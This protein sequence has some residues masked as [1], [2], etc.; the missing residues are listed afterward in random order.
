MTTKQHC[1]RR[2]RSTGSTLM[3]IIVSLAVVLAL[4]GTVAVYMFNAG[5]N[6]GDGEMIEPVKLTSFVHDVVEAGEVESSENEEIRCH[7]KSK[8]TSGTAILWVI[9]EGTYVDQDEVLVKL[10]SSAL[11][12]E[13]LSEKI[14]YNNKKAAMIQA[15]SLWEAAIKAKQEYE[16]GTFIQE[17]QAAEAEVFVAEENLRR[18]QQVALYS[19]R[20]AV[21]GYVTALQL[22]SD[23]FAVEKARKDVE[24]ANTR[25][26][27][28][29][30]FTKGKMVRQ[31]ESDIASAK[32]AY[33]AEKSSFELEETR[34]KEIKDQIAACTL[35]APQAGQV[36]YVNKRDR[37]GNNEFVV[38][39]G[40]L[41]REQQAIIRLPNSNRMQVK[42]KVSEAKISLI[43]RGMP[44]TVTIDAFDSLKLK[45]VVT[46][47]NQYPE[48]S[49]F[50]NANVKEYQTI[51]E[52]EDPPK[53]LKPG[54]TAKVR[55]HTQY[56]KEALQVPI[57]AI[58][59][60]R[61]RYYCIVRGGNAW[62]AKPVVLGPSN[63]KTVVIKE[64]ILEGE[65]VA[66]DP[67]RQLDEVV[68][69][70]VPEPG[71]DEIAQAQREVIAINNPAS[72]PAVS[73]EPSGTGRGQ[74]PPGG[75]AGL[76]NSGGSG[77]FPQDPAE[78]AARMFTRD[79]NGDGKLSPDE[80]PDRIRDQF[81]V[82]DSNHDGAIDRAEMTAAMSQ[83]SRG[84][85][86]PSATGAAE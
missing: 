83:F 49:S 76:G 44:V 45:G 30:K 50:F 71:A 56:I 39:A 64:G 5:Q 55:I 10:D 42:T 69:P 3:F 11:E 26:H 73:S 1:L 36:V 34:L 48:P 79:A 25:L 63:E 2:T 40:A 67:A 74:S 35:R 22:E 8:N 9:A 27:V 12:Q 82:I 68:L 43:R 65:L 13:L 23:R 60:H 29:V 19:E 24:A 46:K 16:D 47:V 17:R 78:M 51:V 4:V 77:G 84:S 75:G 21:K 14:V 7:V 72:L 20:L 38:E 61:G 54:L 33:D 52:I 58:H 59:R 6:N 57:Q 66:M 81:A 80:V 37:R 53:L 31:F 86:G 85:G 28:L 41:L 62:Q 18:A 32:A 15:Q 70:D